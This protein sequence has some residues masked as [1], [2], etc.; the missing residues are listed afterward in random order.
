MCVKSTSVILFMKLVHSVQCPVHSAWCMV[1]KPN[2][3]SSLR[4]YSLVV[5]LVRLANSALH[6]L[7]IVL[8]K[9]WFFY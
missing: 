5:I 1:Q 4:L 6:I 2:G 3:L 7:C 9:A 8:I